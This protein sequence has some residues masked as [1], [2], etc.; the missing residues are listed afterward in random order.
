M[1]EISISGC[2]FQNQSFAE[3]KKEH[4]ALLAFNDNLDRE[5]RIA[6]E[7]AR[8]YKYKVD[9]IADLLIDCSDQELTLKAIKT[10][11]ERVME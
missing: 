10:V 9:M 2:D 6:N 1:S 11:I 4:A 5:R 7:Q 3:L 8:K